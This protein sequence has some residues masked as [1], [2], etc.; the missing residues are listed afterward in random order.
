MKKHFSRINTTYAILGYILMFTFSTIC[1][2]IVIF[3]DS[4]GRK[5]FIIV[6]TL[7]LLLMILY[8]LLYLQTFTFYDKEFKTNYLIGTDVEQYKNKLI[9]KVVIKY[10]DIKKIEERTF[11]KNKKIYLYTQQDE[12]IV[13]D[14]MHHFDEIFEELKKH[15]GN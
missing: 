8:E 14:V 6:V 10:E 9:K 4:I 15:I 5:I 1:T 2:L 7:L 13:V 3:D 11:G 12:L